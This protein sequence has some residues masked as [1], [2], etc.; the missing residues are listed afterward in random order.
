[1]LPADGR[2]HLS[3][4]MTAEDRA[5]TLLIIRERLNRGERCRVVSTSLVEAG[6]DVDFPAVWREMT[7]LDSILQAAGRC[8]REGKRAA[9]E[10]CVHIF[11]GEGRVNPEL[12]LRISPARAVLEAHLELHS[13]E[14][15]A[16][17]FRRL[18][19]ASGDENL[20]K[21]RI[22]QSESRLHFRQTA[23]N[24]RMIDDRGA[25]TVYIPTGENADDLDALRQGF[26][27]RALMRRLGRTAVNCELK[28]TASYCAFW[29]RPPV[30]RA[31]AR[32]ES[33]TPVTG[34]LGLVPPAP[35]ATLP[36]GTVPCRSAST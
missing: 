13:R 15:V 17:Y 26:V 16:M 9:E 24:F 32:A 7:G 28:C 31:A 8:N 6:V 36:S 25:R 27:S 20:D 34:V 22:L 1:M 29:T 30:T 18:I 21:P 35:V 12:M 4:L 3:T 33:T 14:A 11:E 10:S 2:F 23:D 5:K 19:W